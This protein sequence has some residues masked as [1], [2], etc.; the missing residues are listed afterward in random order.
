MAAQA[1]TVGQA[2]GAKGIGASAGYKTTRTAEA[3]ATLAEVGIDK[4]L[5]KSEI[6]IGQSVL[7]SHVPALAGRMDGEQLDAAIDRG[8][9]RVEAAAEAGVSNTFVRH[10]VVRET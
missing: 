9:S 4:N 8:K 2:R 6:K 7:I 5:A 1:K 3:P 10:V